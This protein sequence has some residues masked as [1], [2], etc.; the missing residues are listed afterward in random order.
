MGAWACPKCVKNTNSGANLDKKSVRLSD[1]A[2]IRKMDCGSFHYK[3]LE[4]KMFVQGCPK[5][6]CPFLMEKCPFLKL[7]HCPGFLDWIFSPG[8]FSKND[9]K[10]KIHLLF[11]TFCIIC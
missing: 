6:S 8:Y 7:G 3:N 4:K 5:F 9:K 10:H 11:F 2:L 1:C